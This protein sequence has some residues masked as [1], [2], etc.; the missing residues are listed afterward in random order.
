MDN[1]KLQERITELAQAFTGITEAC[2]AT[3]KRF[4]CVIIKLEEAQKYLNKAKRHN[5]KRLAP[6]TDWEKN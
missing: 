5:M 1:E 3:A 6:D 4:K 2:K